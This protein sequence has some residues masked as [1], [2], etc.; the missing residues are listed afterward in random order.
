MD[1]KSHS[2]SLLALLFIPLFLFLLT[3]CVPEKPKDILVSYKSANIIG[4][5]NKPIVIDSEFLPSMYRIDSYARENGVIVYVTSSFRT[6]DQILTGTIV[7]SS[8]RSNHLAGHA[9]DMNVFYNGD[10]Y[11]SNLLRKS[12]LK[13]RPCNVRNFINDI[14]KDKT[15]RWGGD[16]KDQDPV[17]I[18][19]NL[20]SD[21]N[22]WQARFDACQYGIVSE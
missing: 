9:I 1:K 21:P 16:F 17:H 7:H 2:F 15:L 18:D 14:R 20:N 8:K 6:P 4:Y 19:D 10:L 22:A 11:D 5:E 12:N 3:S 13:N